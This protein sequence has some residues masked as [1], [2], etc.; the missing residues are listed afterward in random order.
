MIDTAK[1]VLT[2]TKVFYLKMDHPPSEKFTTR[3]DISFKPLPKPVDVDDYLTYYASVGSQFNWVDRFLM[4]KEELRAK[5]N[6][7]NVDIYVMNVGDQEAGF[8]ELGKE[9][10]YVELLYFGLFPEFI[11]KRLGKYFLQWAI[12]K[13]WSYN[14]KWI[15]LNTCELDHANALPTYRKLGFK[16][17]KTTIEQRRVQVK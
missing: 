6:A 8:L 5:I 15:Q 14:P 9:A 1:I 4:A 10:D 2:P 12:R 16:D 17:Y 11:G 3:Q 13:A 7:D